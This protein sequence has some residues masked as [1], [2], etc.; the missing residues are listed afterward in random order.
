MARCSR[1]L[2]PREGGDDRVTDIAGTPSYMS[3]EC[4]KGEA[5]GGFASDVWSLGMTM[6]HLLFGRVAFKADNTV[7]LYR[8]IESE[9]VEFPEERM[10]GRFSRVARRCARLTFPWLSLQ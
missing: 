9:E 5:Y 4:V 6:Y 2:Y 1:R 10:A 3:P 7:Q 8:V